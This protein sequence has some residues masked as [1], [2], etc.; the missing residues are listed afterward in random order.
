MSTVAEPAAPKTVTVDG[1]EIAIRPGEN[2]LALTRRSGAAAV[3]SLCYDDRLKSYGSCRMC[4]VKVNGRLVASCTTP[5]APG[6]TVVTDD[7]EIR[8]LRKSLGEMTLSVLPDGPC[9]KCAEDGVCEMHRVGRQVGAESGRFAGPP[10]G[11]KKE[12][13]NPFLGRDYERCIHCYRCVRIC[14]EVQGDTALAIEGRGFRSSITTW[15]DRGLEQS[16][17]E[18]CGQCIHTCPT[19]ALFDKKRLRR[20]PADLR[21]EEIVRTD[22][23]CPYCGTGCGI[24]IQ[25]AR[26][27]LLG[28]T[29]Q[30][31]AGASEGA[32]CVKGQF[33]TDFVESP[34]RL[35]TPLMRRAD[36]K[37]HEASWDEALDYVADRFKAIRDEYGADACAGWASARTTSESNYAFMKFMRGALGSDHLDNCQRT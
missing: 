22:S 26:G 14:D 13:G 16:S 6:A 30:R 21:P 33:G 29:P 10:A 12:D 20:A 18:F 32:L 34:D 24:T 37:L 28:I 11:A 23:T 15:F 9:P 27:K 3:P 31:H 4:V 19:G 2:L 5:P 36:G 1:L 35:K 17:C 7:D 8:A 25:T